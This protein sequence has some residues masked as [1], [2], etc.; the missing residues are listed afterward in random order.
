[1][2]WLVGAGLRYFVAKNVSFDTTLDYFNLSEEID[3]TNV[4]V[5]T[6]GV[7]LGVGITVYMY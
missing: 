3:S 7:S 5:D 1:M 6:E 4:N 2:S